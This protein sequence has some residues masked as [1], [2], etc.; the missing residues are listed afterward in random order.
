MIGRSISVFD[1]I[2]MTIRMNVRKY[3]F[4]N[5]IKDISEKKRVFIYLRTAF[6]YCR[7]VLL[8]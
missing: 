2:G 7:L 6:I 4:I 1:D 5:S 3:S 8:G